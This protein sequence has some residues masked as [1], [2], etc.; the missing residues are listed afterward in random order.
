[1]ARKIFINP[2]IIFANLKLDKCEFML[3][4][5]LLLSTPTAG[6]YQNLNKLSIF[7]AASAGLS[8][9]AQR[10]LSLESEKYGKML[11]RLQ[12]HLYG[13]QAG[14]LRYMESLQ[15]MWNA[16]ECSRL[17]RELLEYIDSVLHQGVFTRRYPQIL[18]SFNHA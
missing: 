9:Q 2:M 14:A 10:I 12:Q 8:K 11:L 6:P 3:L 7:F 18:L 15:V 4:M 1:M 16:I 17:F 13:E 5:N